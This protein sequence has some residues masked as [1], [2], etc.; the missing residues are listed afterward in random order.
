MAIKFPLLYK[1]TPVE[2][3]EYQSMAA[4][5]DEKYMGMGVFQAEEVRQR[6]NE[7]SKPFAIC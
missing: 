1:M 7:F 3:M 2:E 5:R 4:D 6:F